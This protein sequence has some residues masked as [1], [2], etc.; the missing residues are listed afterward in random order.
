MQSLVLEVNLDKGLLDSP[1]SPFN[2][3]D[4]VVS[5]DRSN[6]KLNSKFLVTS[7]AEILEVDLGVVVKEAEASREAPAYWIIDPDLV[8]VPVVICVAAVR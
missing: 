3:S 6:L 4:V 2:S 8:E 5:A 1:D 7:H